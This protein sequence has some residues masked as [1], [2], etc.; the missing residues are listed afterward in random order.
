[1]TSA[2]APA[3]AWGRARWTA[4]GR[5]WKR[6]ASDAAAALRDFESK[7][8]ARILGQLHKALVELATERGIAV[9]VDKASILHGENAVDLTE[10]LHRKVRGLPEPAP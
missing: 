8:S 9:V 10:A 4:R 7:Q 3:T 1:V 5:T 6:P 2:T